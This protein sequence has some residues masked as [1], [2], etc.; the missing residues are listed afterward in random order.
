MRNIRVGTDMICIL[1][2]I[3][4]YNT[5]AH[6]HIISDRIFIQGDSPQTRS[7]PYIFLK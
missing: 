1:Q 3:A 5:A 4:L 2:Y 7:P 6:I